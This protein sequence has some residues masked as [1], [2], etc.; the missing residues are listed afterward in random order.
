MSDQPGNSMLQEDDTPSLDAQIRKHIDLVYSTARRHVSEADAH[1]IVQTVFI[2]F[3]QRAGRLGSNVIVVGWLYRTT[4][5]CCLNLKKLESRRR[6]HEYEV[7]MI[8]SQQSSRPP[9][10]ATLL[11]DAGLSRLRESERV[12]IL[13]HYMEEKTFAQ[14]GQELGIS[15][16][17]ARKVRAS[18]FGTIEILFCAAR[19]P[20]HCSYNNLRRPCGRQSATSF[21][22]PRDSR[23]RSARR[24]H[25][26]R[27]RPCRVA[28][29]LLDQNETRRRPRTGC[30]DAGRGGN[31]H[32]AAPERF[33]HS[34]KCPAV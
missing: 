4:R 17:S 34:L 3:S 18:R 6:K 12:A 7:A 31:P 27:T 2:L 29:N 24:V 25:R 22:P 1:D 23:R 13:L 19:I 30:R 21:G 15:E 10:E 11:L 33:G 5:F 8:S 20:R 32:D 28:R 16:N 9:D 26:R 14:A